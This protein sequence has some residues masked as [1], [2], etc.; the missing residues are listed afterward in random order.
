MVGRYYHLVAVGVFFGW[1]FWVMI[2][3]VVLLFGGDYGFLV[4]PLL[5]HSI[6]SSMDLNWAL[7]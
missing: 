3:S 4:L 7:S 1:K 2:T 5:I 6:A